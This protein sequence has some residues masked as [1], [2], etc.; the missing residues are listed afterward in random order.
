[1]GTSMLPLGK[2]LTEWVVMLPAVVSAL[3]NEVTRLTSKKS[4]DAIR[5]KVVTQ[6]PCTPHLRHVGLTEQKLP[7]GVGVRYL[8]KPGKL[9]GG[10]HCAANPVW[11][12][13]FTD[14]DT[15][16]QSP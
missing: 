12:S 8:Y 4:A 15:L 6:E 9:E 16:S 10:S 2:R 11:Y 5:G 13:R 14:S 7:S 1:M 3:N